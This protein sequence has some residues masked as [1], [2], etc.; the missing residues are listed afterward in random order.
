MSRHPRPA[1]SAFMASEIATQTTFSVRG[2]SA[3]RPC[4]AKAIP[5]AAKITAPTSGTPA[6]RAAITGVRLIRLTMTYWASQLTTAAAAA[7]TARAA[8]AFRSQARPVFARPVTGCG[9]A[10]LLVAV[11]VGPAGRHWPSGTVVIAGLS[12]GGFRCR[13]DQRADLVRTRQRHGQGSVEEPG[14][15]GP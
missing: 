4:S 6:S 10:P 13:G 7:R 2:R 1:A 15:A 3:R 11:P 5:K 14:D 9:V 8:M 12:G